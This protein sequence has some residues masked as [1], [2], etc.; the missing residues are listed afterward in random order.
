[1]ES[2][3]HILRLFT[4]LKKD[5]KQLPNAKYIFTTLTKEFNPFE[6]P[7][8]KCGSK[9]HLSKHDGYDRF[10]VTYEND[11][12]QSNQIEVP[13]FICASCGAT[14]AILPDVLIPYKSYSIFFILHVMQAVFFKAAPIRAIAERFGISVN[15]IYNW[16]KRYLTH[17][18]LELGKLEKYFCERDP[19]LPEPNNIC[20]TE[21]LLSFF[22]RFG[23]SFM[24]YSKAAESRS[25]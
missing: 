12:V 17:K 7:C 20:F 13:R 19:S 24:Q 4:I 11:S 5:F 15:T 21:A 1:M 22:Q 8:P 14:H 9:A 3:V 18:T 10:L 25:Q 23:F 6:S 2:G 16:K